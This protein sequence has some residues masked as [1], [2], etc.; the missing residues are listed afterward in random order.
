[1]DKFLYNVDGSVRYFDGRKFFYADDDHLSE[2]G[3]MEVSPALDA[4]LDGVISRNGSEH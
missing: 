2:A 3:A 1:L 4:V